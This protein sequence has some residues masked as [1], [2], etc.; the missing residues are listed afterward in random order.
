MAAASTSNSLDTSPRAV[1]AA[2]RA[3]SGLTID[4]VF[5]PPDVVDP[6]DTVDWE[7]RSAAIKDETGASCSNRRTVRSRLHGLSWQRTLS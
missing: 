5:C 6:F 1:R 3:H 7:K 4:T 2:R